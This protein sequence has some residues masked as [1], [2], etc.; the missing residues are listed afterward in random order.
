MDKDYYYNET[1]G[2]Y[3]GGSHF[4]ALSIGPTLTVPYVEKNDIVGIIRNP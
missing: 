3:N 1:C 4:R 2:D